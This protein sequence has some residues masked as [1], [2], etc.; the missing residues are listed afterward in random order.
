[1]ASQ[2]AADEA[3]HA[4]WVAE[5]SLKAQVSRQRIGSSKEHVWLV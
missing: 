2:M 4:L 1:M 5:V 3:T